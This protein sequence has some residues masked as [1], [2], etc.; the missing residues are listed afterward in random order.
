MSYI[1]NLV[2]IER[3]NRIYTGDTITSRDV[4]LIAL[5]SSGIT[6]NWDDSSSD[7]Y[8]LDAFTGLKF[9]GNEY[10]SIVVNS[11]SLVRV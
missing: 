2:P 10:T 8:E 4:S 1:D 9:F 6:V 5:E 3:D 7:I 11:G